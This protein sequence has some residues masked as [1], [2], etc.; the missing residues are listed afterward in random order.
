MPVHGPYHASHLYHGIDYSSFLKDEIVEPSINWASKSTTLDMIFA[1]DGGYCEKGFN[2]RELMEK[3]LHEL[4]V[5]NDLIEDMTKEMVR[6]WGSGENRCGLLSCYPSRLGSSIREL[7]QT[8]VEY[9]IAVEEQLFL[10]ADQSNVGEPNR[11][12]RKPRL[13]I[14]GM[15][16]RFPN[17]ADHEKFWDLLAAGMDLHK[18]VR[19]ASSQKRNA[20]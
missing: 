13:A 6:R 8:H 11:R 4:F 19:A 20:Y 5:G 7:L 18:K 1:N 9:E 16:G 3:I 15:A 12:S 10:G 2:G 17:A 14:V